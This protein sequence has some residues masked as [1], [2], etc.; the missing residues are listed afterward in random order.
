MSIAQNIISAKCVANK[1]KERIDILRVQIKKRVVIPPRSS[2]YAE[3]VFDKSPNSDV[4]INPCRDLNGLLSPNCVISCDQNFSLLKNLTDRFITVKRNSAVG[5]GMQLD[6]VF[7]VENS[8]SRVAD[9]QID[10]RSLEI[11]NISLNQ[12]KQIKR[13]IPSFLNRYV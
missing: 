6:Q 13:K 10:V 1:N 5:I 3:I 4:V 12:I 2:V 7:E 8:K 9:E 11:D